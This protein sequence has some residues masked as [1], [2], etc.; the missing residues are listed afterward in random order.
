MI[1]F[2]NVCLNFGSTVIFDE[3]SLQIRLND[4]I[5]LIGPNGAGKST[6][7]KL[8]CK[9]I[10]PSSGSI[11]YAKGVKTGYLPQECFAF[12]KKTVFEEAGSVF[13][14]I[15]HLNRQIDAVHKDLDSPSLTDED[16]QLL[17][18]RHTHLLHQLSVV[19][20]NK[21]NAEI[22][23]VLKGIGFKDADFRK[24]IDALSGG[25]RM[26]VALARLLLQ[27]P[28]ILLLDEPTNHLDVD[29]I[30]WL[31]QYLKEL[32]G[33]LIIISHDRA[34]LDRNVS[35]IWELEKG[36]ITEYHGNYSF[37]ETEKEK[38]SGLQTSRY[39]NQQKKIKEVERFIER[40]RSKNTKASQV[41]SRIKMLGKME[42]ET[43]PEN[44]VHR[45]T[46]RFPP[47][48]Q[49]GASV[50]EVKDV[51]CKYAD[52]WV[53]Q[54][55]CLS[56]ERG[57][58]VALVGQNGSGKSSLLRIINRL[59][60]P[61][62]GTATFGHNV[63]ADYFAQ[64]TAESLQGDNTVLEEVESI[65]PFSMMPHVRHLL[66][67]FLFSGDDVFKTVNV[68]SGGEKSRLCLAKT[69]LKPT[70]FLVLDE[71]TNH[72]DITTKKVL[73]EALLNY[74]GSLLIVS[75]D[76]DF[77][78]GLVSKVYE[79]KDG[80]LFIH[81]GSFKDFLE[82]R[83]AELRSGTHKTA[84]QEAPEL[85]SSGITTQKQIFLQKKEQNA[86]RR[87][88][89]KELQKIEERISYLETQKKEL[90]QTLLDTEL[91]N[92][93]ERHIIINKQHKSV[94]AELNDLYKKW[95]VLHTELEAVDAGIAV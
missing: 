1:R 45:V 46:F 85:K 25:W 81:L 77:L 15:H 80:N 90:D 75:H 10:E 12:S 52:Q 68:L 53:F 7:F 51:S 6:F 64:E 20:A 73:K 31:E 29:S 92:D 42:K 22:E 8:I 32:N 56:I 13:E 39:V 47:A 79:L 19:N 18:D 38:R 33:G 94:S 76:R 62:S 4:R 34:F 5:G 36:N 49:S 69:L 41:Q 3:L 28:D 37:Y 11:I 86:K 59:H 88:F 9:Y 65:A 89:T 84:G 55:V 87:K 67:A 14:D 50:L 71:P 40:F 44:T 66:G 57:E 95:E 93:K 91:Y 35:G 16:R 78:D 23:K 83:E 24:D 26:R 58:K 60:T 74:P 2:H 17:L 21:M 54:G 72:I 43:L 70:N 48:K 27:E 30:L 61:Q 63:L 82:K